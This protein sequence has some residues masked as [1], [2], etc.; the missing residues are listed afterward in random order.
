[1]ILELNS[2]ALHKRKVCIIWNVAETVT[3]LL[4]TSSELRQQDMSVKQC[5]FV[6]QF[7]FNFLT[8]K[9]TLASPCILC[10]T[11][12]QKKKMCILLLIMDDR[13]DLVW[14]LLYFFEY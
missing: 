2:T 3:C 8:N 7:L 12:Y 6:E 1:M 5:S 14:P 10:E 13:R 9:M 11:F 4:D